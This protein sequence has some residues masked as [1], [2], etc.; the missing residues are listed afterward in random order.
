MY[1]MQDLADVLLYQDKVAEAEVLQRECLELRRRTLG[2]DYTDTLISAN[3]LAF[4][5][6]R[7]GMLDEAESR[8]R[9][10][11]RLRRQTLAA[12]DPQIGY[13]LTALGGILAQ[14]GQ[15]KEAL[16]LLREAASILTAKPTTIRPASGALHPGLTQSL[17]GDCLARQK[18]FAAA[19]TLLLAAYQTLREAVSVP[20]WQVR[21]AKERIVNLYEAWN[22][23]EQA[24]AW[25][26]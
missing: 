24:A 26:K 15:H 23:P 25:R 8:L 1:S 10:T 5:L 7:A 3:G 22:K 19:E 17:L 6:W 4:C 9:D 21:A 14:K 13:T 20:P 12:D 18:D 11:L 16:P 2:P